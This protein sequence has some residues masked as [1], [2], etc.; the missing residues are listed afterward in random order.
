MRRGWPP[1]VTNSRGQLRDYIVIPCDEPHPE[2]H[3]LADELAE[4]RARKRAGLA[5]GE[6]FEGQIIHN[7]IHPLDLEGR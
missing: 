1:Q 5:P 2:L 7:P 4:R 3:A 6:R